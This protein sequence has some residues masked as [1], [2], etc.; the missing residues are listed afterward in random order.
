MRKFDGVFREGLTHE[1][2][3]WIIEVFFNRPIAHLTIKI[4]VVTEIVII[5]LMILYP[6]ATLFLSCITRCGF[7]IN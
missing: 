3:T 5:F 1:P 4:D 7:D 2:D 6:L